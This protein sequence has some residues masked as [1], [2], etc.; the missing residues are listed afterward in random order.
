MPAK[1]YRYKS[2]VRLKIEYCLHILARAAQPSLSR[3]DRVKM[4]FRGL[5]DEKNIFHYLSLSLQTLPHRRNITFLSP[6]Y[7]YFHGKCSDELEFRQFRPS[8]LRSAM[9]RTLERII[10][11][12]FAFRQLKASF[13][14]TGSSKELPLRGDEPLEDA[15]TI[16]TTLTSLI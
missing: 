13:I 1:L 2:H 3:L 10:L 8:F 6:L 16:T 4:R 15:S 11:F 9:L 12:T 7:R 5:V 14:R